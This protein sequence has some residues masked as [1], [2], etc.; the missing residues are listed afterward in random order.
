MGNAKKDKKPQLED[1]PITDTLSGHPKD[2][3]N[4]AIK[5]HYSKISPNES[6]SEKK[7]P[8]IPTK[9]KAYKQYLQ[10]LLDQVEHPPIR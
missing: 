5:Q 7:V 3:V 10:K 4:A 2:F 8:F 1:A 6:G 9:D